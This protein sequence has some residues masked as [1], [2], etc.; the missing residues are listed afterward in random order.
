MIDEKREAEIDKYRE[1]YKLPNYKMGG[2][3]MQHAQEIL[4]SLPIRG[5]YLDIGCGRGEMLDF[6]DSIE[7]EFT[8][9]IETG[10]G[11]N[12]ALAFFK[13]IKG[14][15]NQAFAVGGFN[16]H[17]HFSLAVIINNSTIAGRDGHTPFRIEID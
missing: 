4:E 11:F 10:Q 8:G 2:A 1:V 6:A 12:L 7:F 5:Y 13:L 9:G 14:V 3:R 15:D 17:H 16:G